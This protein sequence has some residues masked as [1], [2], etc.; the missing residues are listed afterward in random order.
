[1]GIAAQPG[2][3]RPAF[4]GRSSALLGPGTRFVLPIER[5]ATRLPHELQQVSGQGA[6]CDRLAGF[7]AKYRRYNQ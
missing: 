4:R 1:M 2:A 3:E 5:G 6:P 7:R